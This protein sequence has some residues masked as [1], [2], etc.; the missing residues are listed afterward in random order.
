MSASA[1]QAVRVSYLELD[2]GFHWW[3]S[4][5]PQEAVPDPNGQHACEAPT[6]AECTRNI[7][8]I[9][10]RK[11]K[12]DTTDFR[13]GAVADQEYAFASFRKFTK[14]DSPLQAL[15]PFRKSVKQNTA[16]CNFPN[17]GNTFLSFMGL[18]DF[19]ILLNRT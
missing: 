4:G 2:L 7:H 15:V 9:R 19:G 12:T 10:G 11:K 14:P 16:L 5:G 18:H 13:N 8:W 3:L 17:V 1:T 6:A